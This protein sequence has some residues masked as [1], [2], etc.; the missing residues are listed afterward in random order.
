MKHFVLFLLLLMFISGRAQIANND[1]INYNTGNGKFMHNTVEA[2]FRDQMGYVWVGTNF[3]LSRLDGYSTVT[4]L[5]NENNPRS[6]S[7]NFIKSIFVDSDNIVWIGTVGG[8]LNRY[9][10]QTNGFIH[11]I[12]DGTNKSVDSYNIITINEDNKG[13]I[14]IGTADK[15]VDV[16]NKETGEFEFIDLTKH[17][18]FERGIS[19]VNSIFSDTKGNVWIGM[20][21][22]EVFCIHP[23]LDTIDFYCVPYDQDTEHVGAITDIA[24]IGDK[25]M[26]STWSGRIYYVVPG[27]T[28]FLELLFP[29]QYFNGDPLMRMI[30]DKQNNLWLA[31]RTSGLYCFN[32]EL[33]QKY[34]FEHI[35]NQPSSLS[36]NSI[37]EMHLDNNHCLWLGHL[38]NGLGMLPINERIFKKVLPELK[39]QGFNKIYSIIAGA[40][41]NIW[42]GSRSSGL[43][44]YNPQSGNYKQYTAEK[45]AGLNT[46]SILSLLYTDDNKIVVGTDG[47]FISIF[48]PN[49]ETF[50]QVPHKPDDWSSGVFS[51][52]ET[53]KHYWAAT[54]GGGIK[55]VDKKTLQY[56][57]INFDDED[58]F[59]NSVFD[60]EIIDSILWI[61]NVGRGLI[62]YNVHTNRYVVYAN[63]DTYTDFPTGRINDIYVE[64]KNSLWLSTDG[65]GIYNFIPSTESIQRHPVNNNLE[66][67]II[68]ASVI[69]GQNDVWVTTISGIEKFS[70]KTGKVSSFTSKNGLHN[71]AFNQ[72]AIYFDK[73]ND[74]IYA[75]SLDGVN[76]FTPNQAVVDSTL[77][78]VVIT[79]IM[80]MGKKISESDSNHMSDPVDL[81]DTLH[82]YHQDK[83]F[84]IYFSSLEY[85]P[86]QKNKYYYKL[87]G[88]NKDWVVA[89][90]SNNYVQYTNLS[91]GKYIFKVKSCNSD[92]VCAQNY[93]SI[94]IVMHPV[95][96]QT[97]I[98]RWLAFVFVVMLV[99]L[100]TR[101][102][103]LR[104]L[105]SQKK[106]EMLVE[107]RTLEITRQ[108]ERIEK[109]NRELDTANRTKDKFLSVIGHDLRGPMT[110]INQM[111]ELVKM[112]YGQVSNEE[113]L[114][115]INLIGNSSETTVKLLDDLLL[116]AQSQYNRDNIV[117]QETELA[118]IFDQVYNDLFSVALN[119]DVPIVYPQNCTLKILA[120]RNSI[121]LVL[122]NLVSNAIKFSY[123]GGKITLAADE[124]EN[125]VKISVIDQGVGIAPE[126][127]EKI[128]QFG[129][130]S[131]KTGTEGEIGT[132]L[133]LMLCK[134]FIVLNNGE[135]FVESTPKK[136]SVFSFMV[137]KA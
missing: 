67:K 77:N 5:H 98:F 44:K 21:Q 99:L 103:Y 54:W 32:S 45:Y 79:E 91:A 126:Y 78:D 9:D 108:K 24:Q 47:N 10:R 128:M 37:I 31:S 134:E 46:N 49:S 88:F 30:T 7:N 130:I 127:V 120:D 36:S 33:K 13:R 122:R 87:E 40:N 71:G 60:I 6:L 113:I 129:K 97:P 101:L 89:D 52:R 90:Y 26:F 58:Q 29:L 34:H 105:R 133:G 109:Q 76:V 11:Y 57:S 23:E 92:G 111:V 135:L 85:A 115:Y 123:R 48:D 136:G 70:K 137:N 72:A 81:I 28:E 131:S 68:Q 95:W 19:N 25:I 83:I 12:P 121:L 14:W 117:L 53:A 3:G 86:T 63:S 8:G 107:Q 2:I 102:R 84:T 64:N 100:I 43:W 61:A 69:D 20:S 93:T 51:V 66:K 82:L 96:W 56:Q 73:Q 106:L 1:F 104:L 119:K 15:T 65:S 124:I 42:F 16:Y 50:K 125:K 55:K 4:Y 74:K 118:G 116:W 114:E 80:V 62:K 75:G 132:G 41:G 112:Q 59:N 94:V 39:N 35:I 22:G 27:Q 18:S 38:D 17:D 110:T